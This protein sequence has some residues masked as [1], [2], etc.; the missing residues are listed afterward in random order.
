MYLLFFQTDVVLWCREKEAACLSAQQAGMV[1]M[2]LLS[3][4]HLMPCAGHPSG[5]SLE[6][7]PDKE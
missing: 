4:P 5:Y 6:Q 1:A 2:P 3:P 7:E